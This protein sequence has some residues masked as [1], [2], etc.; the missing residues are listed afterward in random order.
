MVKVE[1]VSAALTPRTRRVTLQREGQCLT[2]RQV[3]DL[4]QNDEEFVDQL[5]QA[6]SKAP[7]DAFF[8]ELPALSRASIDRPCEF[9]LVESP[10]L[11]ELEADPVPFVDYFS[12]GADV[13]TFANQS[14]DTT[15]IAPT[16]RGPSGG[17]SHLADFCRL[18][19]KAQQRAFWRAVG[20]VVERGLS[21]SPHWLSTSGLGVAWL[22]A[23]WD[24]FPKYYTHVPYRAVPPS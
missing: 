2:F 11:A 17:Y 21:D 12:S 3:V 10:Q 18:G 7:F 5:C 13:V 8:W 1:V 15:L 6:L 19:D 22:H 24:P 20:R 23:R 16:P 9:V 4:W 14:G